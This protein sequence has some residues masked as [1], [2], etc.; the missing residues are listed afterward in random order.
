[1]FHPTAWT[2][3]LLW[4]VCAHVGFW[5]MLLVM[6]LSVPCCPYVLAL[7][8]GTE[9][10]NMR[11]NQ[12]WVIT[13]ITSKTPQIPKVPFGYQ[14]R[15]CILDMIHIFLDDKL[16]K[17]KWYYLNNLGALWALQWESLHGEHL[18]EMKLC[19]CVSYTFTR[20][21]QGEVAFSATFLK[22]FLTSLFLRL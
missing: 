18:T 16:L 6:G 8:H 13:F 22:A 15:Y 9:N 10:M 2:H 20:W 12:I 1:M 11:I 21:S 14:F 19:Y 4:H 5:H 17:K 7:S 3:I